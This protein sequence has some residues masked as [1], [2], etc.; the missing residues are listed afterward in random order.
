L[1]CP[2]ATGAS[3]GDLIIT[4]RNDRRL[5]TSPTDW[6]KNGDRWIILHVIGTGGVRVRHVRNGRTV[7]LPAGYVATATELGY[8]STVHTAQGVTADTMHGV[9]TGEESRQQLYTM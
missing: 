3:V 8:A 5:R 6:V 4:R 7:T 2:T 1:S 9:V